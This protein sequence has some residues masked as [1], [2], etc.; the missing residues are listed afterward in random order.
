ML[1][2]AKDILLERERVASLDH[3]SRCAAD[4]AGAM[5]LCLIFGASDMRAEAA[6]RIAELE[7]ELKS[8]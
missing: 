8:L 7:T 5:P 4:P 1:G 3:H 6:R 2:L